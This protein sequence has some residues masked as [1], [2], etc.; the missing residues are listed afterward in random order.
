MRYLLILGLITLLFLVV[1]FALVSIPLFANAN[2]Y[3][4][5]D[6][7]SRIQYSNTSLTQDAKPVD[8]DKLIP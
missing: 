6:V 7:N 4:S 1:L 8:I 3:K 2:I 5:I